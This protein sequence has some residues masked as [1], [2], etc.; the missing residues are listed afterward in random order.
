MTIRRLFE[1]H[2]A[3]LVRFLYRR[4]GDRD[5]AED[6]AQEAFVRLLGRSPRRPESWLYAVAANLAR[7]EAR[8][9]ARRA[10]RLEA[11]EGEW[12]ERAAAAAAAAAPDAALEA[13]EAAARVRAALGRLGERDRTILLLRGEGLPYREVAEVLGV[14]ATSVGPLL[15]RAQRRFLRAY[16]TAEAG[17]ERDEDAAGEAGSSG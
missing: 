15:N 10:R 6:L 9:A 13:D 7:D 5:R 2:Y 8:G 4:L 17:K 14:A 16:E 12:T 3:R 1:R 11:L